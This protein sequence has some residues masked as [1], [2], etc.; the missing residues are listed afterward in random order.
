[1][2]Y[3]VDEGDFADLDDDDIGSPSQL[4]IEDCDV[5]D[6]TAAELETAV[7]EAAKLAEHF[8][9][10]TYYVASEPTGEVCLGHS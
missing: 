6:A 4:R 5:D 10:L 8:R 2:V 1:M 9:M 3:A 7:D